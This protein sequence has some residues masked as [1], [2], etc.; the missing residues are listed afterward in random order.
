MKS[1][2]YINLKLKNSLQAKTDA[3]VARSLATGHESA[4][5]KIFSQGDKMTK[6]LVRQ[7]IFRRWVNFQDAWA[8]LSEQGDSK[9]PRLSLL[10]TNVI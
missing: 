7:A 1:I 8:I 5:S 4:Q 9:V 2:N 10:A 6:K 3:F